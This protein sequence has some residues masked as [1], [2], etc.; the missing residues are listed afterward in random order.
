MAHPVTH[1]AKE[2]VATFR[3]CADPA[4]AH[5]FPLG[6]GNEFSMEETLELLT[7]VGRKLDFQ[8]ADLLAWTIDQVY[9]DNGN[10]RRGTSKVSQQSCVCGFGDRHIP[11]PV[12]L[13]GQPLQAP[14]AAQIAFSGSAYPGDHSLNYVCPPE[15]TTHEAPRHLAHPS[16]YLRGALA[17]TLHSPAGSE[18]ERTELAELMRSPE[19]AALY[20]D[21]QRALGTRSLVQFSGTGGIREYNE[22]TTALASHFEASCIQNTLLKAKLAAYTLAGHARSWWMSH[23]KYTPPRLYSLSQ[24]TEWVQVELVPE[25]SAMAQQR[26]WDRLE[27]RSDL[28]EYFSTVADT[29]RDYPLP[30]SSAYSHASRPFGIALQDKVQAAQATSGPQGL[31]QSQWEA[32]VRDYVRT[33]EAHPQFQGWMRGEKGPRLRLPTPAIPRNPS[34]P[35]RTPHAFARLAAAYPSVDAT[36]TGEVTEEEAAA[37]VTQVDVEPRKT[38]PPPKYG[39]GPRPCFCCGSD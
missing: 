29:F 39:I 21:L 36:G 4:R 33:M 3:S 32:I 16:Y 11:P 17:A 28:R 27:F 7:K 12:F 34:T 37:R 9:V 25:C 6:T 5:S 18:W 35:P 38:G 2:G 23:G 15:A 22:W 26:A 30:L 19:W 10:T 14:G 31:M 24:L 8:C 13:P 20:R 1:P